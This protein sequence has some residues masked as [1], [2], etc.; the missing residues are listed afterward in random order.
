MR[1]SLD[2][3]GE[4]ISSATVEIWSL[5]ADV[6]A[7]ELVSNGPTL[8]LA[9][10]ARGQD[11]VATFNG[12]AGTRC[13]SSTSSTPGSTYASSDPTARASTPV[14]AATASCLLPPSPNRCVYSRPGLGGEALAYATVR[15]WTV[16]DR[17]WWL[18]LGAE[19]P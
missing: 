16:P 6:A 14:A 18:L 13:K 5:P 10:S 15:I 19:S 2:P 7:G 11:A 4:T 17:E 8:T 9:N 1:S 3:G 12:V